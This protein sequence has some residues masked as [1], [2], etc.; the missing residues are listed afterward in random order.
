MASNL[1][2]TDITSRIIKAFFNVYNQL[3]YGFLENV[4]QR[5]LLLEMPKWG[6]ECSKNYPIKVYYDGLSI[7]NYF[8]D[9]VVEK[10]VIIEIKAAN[11]I[12]MEHESQLV[13]YLKATGIEV[14]L[15]LNFGPVAQFKRKIFTKDFHQKT[16]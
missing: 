9:I 10:S 14:G 4:Y 8:A 15:L 16:S 5:A 2:H 1:L 6:L 3:G 7:G 12:C 11:A 13:N